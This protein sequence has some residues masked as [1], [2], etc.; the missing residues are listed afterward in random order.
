MSAMRTSVPLVVCVLLLAEGVMGSTTGA[1]AGR[2]RD[3][4][5]GE[6]LVGAVVMLGGDTDYGAVVGVK[7]HYLI[8]TL[9]ETAGTVIG[10]DIGYDAVSVPYRAPAGCTTNMDFYLYRTPITSISQ[11]QVA[12]SLLR[13][14]GIDTVHVDTVAVPLSTDERSAMLRSNRVRLALLDRYDKGRGYRAAVTLEV[15]R[16]FPRVLR[17]RP[18]ARDGGPDPVRMDKRASS[19]IDALR[20]PYPIRPYAMV[21]TGKGVDCPRFAGHFFRRRLPVLRT[22]L[23]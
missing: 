9:P 10:A 5:S 21:A 18:L 17:E 4:L 6:P 23:G 16:P 8:P 14:R 15:W 7:G 22:R 19:P 1:L 12:E 3:A 2:V 20:G 13:S 11:S